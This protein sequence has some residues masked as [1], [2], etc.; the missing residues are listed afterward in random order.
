MPSETPAAAQNPNAPFTMRLP[1]WAFRWLHRSGLSRKTLRGGF[2]HTKLGDRLLDRSL[3]LPKRTSLARAWLIGF[4]IT[5][6]PF[7]P[8]QSVLA[9]IL[10]FLARANLLLCIGLQFLSNFVTAPFHL[11]A[12]YFVGRV[13]L[14]EHPGEVWAHLM[15]HPHSIWSADALLALYLGSIILG[16]LIGL[17][18]YAII[19]LFWPDRT[20]PLRER[21]L[22]PHRKHPAPPPIP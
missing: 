22:L 15:A 3:W 8:F 9:G 1:L 18:G 7:L 16:P 19:M 20:Y 2:L 10:G 12:C 14:G 6:V 17:I 4:P 13:V 5:T 21:H 11:S